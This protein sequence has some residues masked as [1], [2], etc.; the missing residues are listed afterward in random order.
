MAHIDVHVLGV[1]EVKV[2]GRII[3]FPYKKAEALFYFLC[4]NKKTTREILSTLL[5]SDYNDESA[6]KNLRNAIYVIKNLICEDIII[7]PNRSVVELNPEVKIDTDIDKLNLYEDNETEYFDKIFLES[8]SLKD[9]YDFEEWLREKRESYQKISIDRLSMLVN[10]ALLSKNYI[11]AE[12]YLLK[13]IKIDTY[14]EEAY[15]QLMKVYRE[16]GDFKK[17]LDYYMK[18]KNYLYDELGIKPDITTQRLY[19]SIKMELELVGSEDKD[20]SFFGRIDELKMM[21]ER[22]ELF[23]KE[24]TSQCI[25]IQGEAG[26]GK[27]TLIQHFIDKTVDDST[28]ILR[29]YCYQA[30]ENFSL[31]PWNIILEQLLKTLDKHDIKI[32]PAKYQVLSFFFPALLPEEQASD[33]NDMVKLN[34]VKYGQIIEIILELLKQAA[35]DKRLFLIIDDIQWADNQSIKLVYELLLRSKSI[36]V[37]FILSGRNEN[38]DNKLKLIH[39]FYRNNILEVIELKRLSKEETFDFCRFKLKMYEFNNGLLKRI[40]KETEGNFFFIIEILNLLKE[41]KDISNLSNKMQSIMESRLSTVSK[42]GLQ[43]LNIM[44][45]FFDDVLYSTLQ[46]L[47]GKEHMKMVRIIEELQ[48]KYLIKEIM[49]TNGEL[50]YRFTHIKIHEYIYSRL[51]ASRKRFLHNRVALYLEDKY[52]VTEYDDRIVTRLIHHFS[53]SGNKLKELEYR[54]KRAKTYLCF[55]YELFPVIDDNVF[56]ELEN[57]SYDYDMTGEQLKIIE[58]LIILMSKTHSSNSDFARMESDFL[59]MQGSLFIQKGNYDDGIRIIAKMIKKAEREGHIINLLNG[60]T[61][62]CYYGIQTDNKDIL[63]EYSVKM[64][65]ISKEYSML[66][67]YGIA[68]R[69]NGLL[70]LMESDY[71]EAE[72]FFNESIRIFKSLETLYKKYTFSITAGLNYIGDTRLYSG[73]NEEALKLYEK[74]IALSEGRRNYM[75]MSLFYANAGHASFNMCKYELSRSFFEKSLAYLNE[76]KGGWVHP[77]ANSFKAL[78]LIYEGDYEGGLHNLKIADMY[79]ERLKKK[80]W[81]GINHRVKAEIRTLMD[82]NKE[83]E[84]YFRDYLVE[85]ADYYVNSAILLFKSVGN[86]HGVSICSKFKN[87]K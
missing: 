10:N 27:S 47:S 81:M 19:Q 45:V 82:N 17:A 9:A 58:E 1:P 35:K 33:V 86:N 38:L 55:G 49:D 32:S 77:I 57:E 7:T 14:N 4:V 63:A 13:L 23:R 30:E 69:F 50:A 29:S 44:S 5:W 51:S 54:I 56:I 25:V 36:P 67:E 79:C 71:S 21:N 72:N 11:E 22:L 34:P 20:P 39:T 48:L 46:T 68:L 26:V 80:Y 59:A 15:R 61:Q 43:I 31:R 64:Y 76:V 87:Q 6:R 2:D 74:C 52:S 70:K 78:L 24:N 73:N 40:Y 85:N 66:Q 8:F 37:F 42:D 83:I 62:M 84:R 60:L 16:K 41:G 28:L 18:L 3:E 53:Q 75:S 65:N 12:T